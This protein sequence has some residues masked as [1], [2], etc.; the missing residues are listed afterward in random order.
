MTLCTP[1]WAI[2][3]LLNSPKLKNARDLVNGMLENLGAGGVPV[4]VMDK[5]NKALGF[6]LLKGQ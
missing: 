2:L 3:D 1:A 5:L 6:D 4:A